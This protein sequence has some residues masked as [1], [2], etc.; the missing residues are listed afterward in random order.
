MVGCR[1]EQQCTAPLLLMSAVAAGLG[2]CCCFHIGHWRYQLEWRDWDT[3]A[4]VT[5][6]GLLMPAAGV[7]AAAVDDAQVNAH[8]PALR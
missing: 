6:R 8:T 4:V 5:E 2:D 7:C 1:G 3:A